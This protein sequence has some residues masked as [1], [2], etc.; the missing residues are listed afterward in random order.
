MSSSESDN[1]VLMLLNSSDDSS[2][3]TRSNRVYKTR[4]NY[5]SELDNQEFQ[6]RFRLDKQSV[7]LLLG[8]IYPFLK[9]KGTRNHGISPLHYNLSVFFGILARSG[10]HLAF[11]L[12]LHGVLFTLQ[13]KL[14]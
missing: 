14:K 2:D 4:I 13:L 7:Q 9:V 5:Y 3:D 11:P 12:S 8:E 1:E 6:L 10:R